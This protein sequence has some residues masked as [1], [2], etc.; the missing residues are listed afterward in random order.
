MR[1]VAK[2]S[3][4]DGT[5]EVFTATAAAPPFCCCEKRIVLKVDDEGEGAADDVSSLM[6]T[7]DADTGL[8]LA[9]ELGVGT[10]ADITHSE[11]AGRG[12]TGGR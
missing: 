2:L 12:G 8:A 1:I 5:V 6:P 7:S 11:E 3:D 10:G 4:D 9:A